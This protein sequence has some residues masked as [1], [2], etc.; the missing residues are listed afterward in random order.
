MT[1]E[2]EAIVEDLQREIR[3]NWSEQNQNDFYLTGIQ[4]NGTMGHLHHSLGRAVRNNYNLWSMSW[5]PEIR[6]GIDYSPYHP[7]CLSD[8]IL[9][10]VWSRGLQ[11][12][13]TT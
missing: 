12:K 2:I 7:D 13:E 1:P 6:G 4:D 9:K 5:E 3:D 8:T 11:H 10:E